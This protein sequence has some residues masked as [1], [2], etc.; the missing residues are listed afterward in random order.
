MTSKGW[1]NGEHGIFIAKDEE[2]M[3]PDLNWGLIEGRI[4]TYAIYD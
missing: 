3:P 2:N 4:Y 1:Y